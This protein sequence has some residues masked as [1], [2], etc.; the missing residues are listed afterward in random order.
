MFFETIILLDVHVRGLDVD[1]VI[2]EDAQ[3]DIT[4]AGSIPCRPLHANI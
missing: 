1:E 2:S 4:W 3:I